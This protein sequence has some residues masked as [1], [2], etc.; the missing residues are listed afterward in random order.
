[1]LKQA[2]KL[3][4][5]MPFLVFALMVIAASGARAANVSLEEALSPKVLGKADAPL[6]MHEYSS[7]SCPH[8]AAFDLETLP[9]IKKE[10]IDT[11]KLK[12]VYHDFPLNPPAIAAAMVLRCAGNQKYFPLMDMLFRAQAQWAASSDPVAGIKKVVR[13]AAISDTDVDT[14]L[15]NASLLHAIQ[16]SAQKAEK[17]LGVNSTPT[18][19]LAGT[20]IPGALSIADF[21]NLIDSKLKAMGK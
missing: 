15:S 20:K 18:F 9:L 16:D 21:R 13:F 17:D 6:T 2:Q 12:L 19:F 11:G 1:M 3:S 10:Y 8:C 4:R 14:C 7:M 5:I